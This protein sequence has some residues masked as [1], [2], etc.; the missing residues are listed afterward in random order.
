MWRLHSSLTVLLSL[1]VSVFCTDEYSKEDFPPGFVFGAATSAY[2]VEG[3][4][5]MDGRS[6]SIWDTF[7]HS[8]NLHGD[9]GDV[10]VDQYH[11]YK[12]DVQLMA[13]TGLE[14]YRFSIS[15]SRLIPNGRGTLNPKGLQ[16]Y[17]NL[18]NELVSHGIQPHVTLNHMDHPQVLEDEYGGWLSRKMVED[19]TAYADVCFREFGDR[20]WHWVT[21]NELNVFAIGSYDLGMLPPKRCSPPFGLNCSQGNS[22]YE[23]YLAVH[24]MLLAHAF[25]ARLYRTKYKEKQHGFI[26]LSLYGFW[27]QPLTNSAED[28]TAT[29]RA[30][31][32]FLGWTAKPLVFG[33]YPDIMKK[34]VGSR[35][36]SFSPDESKLVKGSI[37]FLGFIHYGGFYINDN[38]NSPKGDVFVDAQV[39]NFLLPVAVDYPQKPQANQDLVPTWA[40]KGLLHCFKQSY[41]NPPVYILENG[42]D[43]PRSSSLE[44]ISRVAYLHTYIGA[45]LDAIRAGSNTRG[46]FVWSLLDILEILDGYRTSFG[47]YY[48]DLDDPDLKRQPKLS[49]HWYSQFLKGKNTSLDGIVLKVE[50]N[51]SFQFF[52]SKNKKRQQF[53]INKKKLFFF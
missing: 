5:N 38:S 14:A 15:W 9:T 19:F 6:P 18:I 3:A 17:N 26:G 1:A 35:L 42:K 31:E 32:F 48:V 10:A 30:K 40:L 27:F 53:Y 24:H 12:E 34:L 39:N 16:Y 23:P 41:G 47:L 8:G 2:Q 51:I 44:D 13:E 45:V 43:T 22:T 28:V 50:N 37:D 11:K 33:N 36:P 46:Y 25:T 4:A 52:V 20:V 7:T 49:A 29:E 21:I